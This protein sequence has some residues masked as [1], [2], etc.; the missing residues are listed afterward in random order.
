LKITDNVFNDVREILG[1]SKENI[2]EI[3]RI[4]DKF[5]AEK[6]DQTE[7]DDFLKIKF[8]R[9]FLDS[10]SNYLEYI[11]NFADLYL[12]PKEGSEIINFHNLKSGILEELKLFSNN[13][14]NLKLN[15][16]NIKRFLKNNSYLEQFLTTV[17]SVIDENDD[18]INKF[19]NSLHKLEGI[20]DDIGY[21]WIEANKIKNLNLKINNFPS[22]ITKWDE[23]KELNDFIE[24]S[25]QDSIKKRKKKKKGVFLTSYFN[26]IYQFFNR[27]QDDK[28]NI[29][30]DLIFLLF[31]NNLIEEFN[32]VEDLDEFVNVLDRK[33]IIQK[34]K[35]FLRPIVKSLIEDKLKSFLNEIEELDK[36]FK[37]EEDKKKF[38][39]KTLL[40]Q[41]FSL[42]LPKIA[43]YYLSG[44]EKKYQATINDLKEYDEF[45]N[46]AK[47]YSEKTELFYSLI[48]K[49][50]EYINE[51]EW[52][53]MP[54]VEVSDSYKKTI[55]NVL[56][57]ITRR[58]N[59]YV[60]YLKTVRK[61]RLRDRV[62]NFIYEKIAEVN[63]LM[64]KYQDDTALIVREEFPQ[65]K[66]I[67]DILSNYKVSIQKIKDEVYKKLDFY[68]EKDIDIYQIIKQWEDNFTLK[69]QQLSFLL[70]MMLN[71][72]FKNFKE[73]IEEEGLML[74]HITEIT[75]QKDTIETVP[76]N[77]AL[78]NFLVDKLTEEE[79]NE[80][81]G[82]IKVRIENLS[83]E[84]Y[85]YQ[86]E[87]TNLQKTLANRVKI[88]EGITSDSI[89]CGVCHKQFDFAKE[90][91]IKCPF[92]D[93][94]YH[95]LCVAFWLSKYNSCPAC[96]NKFLD[97]G[98]GIYSDQEG[99]YEKE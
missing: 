76:L 31:Q 95:Y 72:L 78:S 10:Y 6:S 34:L 28:I 90:Q 98:A 25:N 18:L 39:L 11:R 20:Y 8:S 32:E 37:L 74:K 1:F 47:F 44:L 94:V 16:R 71:K 29:Y 58:S 66:Q 65:I 36:N 43:E 82:E 64:S 42:Y 97:P 79:L 51:F 81:I 48:E 73:L 40:E 24:E 45:K 50:L 38:N 69:K 62:R 9:E 70:S 91:I 46:V 84:I 2:L 52:C 77:F 14:L 63:D 53:L 56:S 85:L 17:Q 23:I 41:E 15:C 30:S 61:E 22:I 4:I 88:R 33:E 75:D 21:I 89:R 60:F 5:R 67:R 55:E 92:C 27:K 49:I 93:A 7:I 99:E 96:Q 35:K 86:S 3:K 68:K 19:E 54:Y 59:E 57:E 87:L 26:D 12:L 83:K 80:R 13:L